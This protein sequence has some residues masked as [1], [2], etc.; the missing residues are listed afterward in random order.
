MQRHTDH[1]DWVTTV[2]FAPDGKSVASA[3]RDKTVRLWYLDQLKEQPIVLVSDMADV[4]KTLSFSGNGSLLKVGKSWIDIDA[5]DTCEGPPH[6]AQRASRISLKEEWVL[7]DGKEILW[8]P[9]SYRA[10]CSDVHGDLLVLGH[11]S[12]RIIFLEFESDDKAQIEST[13]SLGSP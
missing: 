4:P 2:A 6:Q 13:C 10:S 9:P 7:L 5:G 1:E 8:L 12:G 11:D 3:S